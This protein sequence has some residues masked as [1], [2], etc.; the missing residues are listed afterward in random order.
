MPYSSAADA[1]SYV[2]KAKRAQWIA[3]WN[4][5]YQRALKAGKSQKDAE[6]SAFAQANGVAKKESGMFE[7][8]SID[9]STVT[10]AHLPMNQSHNALSG[11]LEEA[12]L[13]AHYPNG[14]PNDY[15]WSSGPWVHDVFPNHVVYRHNGETMRRSYTATYP[16]AGAAPT[17]SLG[18]PRSVHR[19]YVLTKSGDNKEAARALFIED[20]NV[21]LFAV[22]MPPQE[23][24]ESVTVTL[25]EG[26][27]MVREAAVFGDI[28]IKKGKVKEAISKIPVKIIGPGWGSMAYYSKEVL[29]RDGPKVFTPG[30]QMFWNH[31]TESEE[32]QR[33]EGD[34]NDLAAVLTKPAYWDD[35]GPKGPGLYSE[36]KVFS[37]YATQVA[38]KGAHIGVSINAAI[39]GKEGTAEG[40]TGRICEEFVKAFSTDFVT[41]AGA[42]GAPVV[43]VMESNRGHVEEHTMTEQE[44]TALQNENKTLKERLDKIAESQNHVL[45][46]AT[47]SAVLREAKIPFSQPLLEL[48]CTTPVMKEGKVD[49]EWVKKVVKGFS[50]GH[51]GRVVG[52]GEHTTR[53]SEATPED[54]KKR[55]EKSLESLGV[56]KAG[57]EYAVAGRV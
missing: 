43:P 2:P 42:G 52:F 7:R 54:I 13:K 34:L 40:R 44:V 18:E 8:F 50:E 29:Q 21:D 30:T 56:P 39:R 10:E 57:L 32:V 26:S 22:T 28:E 36:A 45:A 53:E 47:V 37:D 27:Q 31:A 41:K 23:P 6:A 1:P 55:L 49:E 16:Q 38:E 46:I 24:T 19:A 3:V 15:S 20:P 14:K 11:H 25:P 51:E 9:I 48:A 33:P 17:I 4:S 35:K 12:L 5:A